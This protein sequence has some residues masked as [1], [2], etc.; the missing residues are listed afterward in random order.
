MEIKQ[1]PIGSLKPHPK[2]P[3]VHPDSAIEKLMRSI[4]EF[5]WTNPI[6]V[7]ED[8][9][10]M[11]GHARVKA[12]IKAGINE[13]PVIY[14]PLS[15]QKAEM[16][17]LTDNGVQDEAEWDMPVLAELLEQFKTSNLDATLTAFDVGEIDKIIN[18]L[19]PKQGLT[20]D[21]AIPEP[22]ESICKRGELWQL[23]NHRLLCGDATLSGDVERL[24]GSEKADMVFTDPPYSSGGYQEAGKS[25]GSIGSR[26]SKTIMMDNLSTRGYR[27]LIE[28]TL[29]I[30]TETRILFMFTDWRMWIESFDIA[31]RIGFRVRNML[32]WDKINFGMGSPFRSQHEL[33]LFGLKSSEDALSPANKGNVFNIKR[34]EHK[35]HFTMKPV[36][37]IT[38]VIGNV[39][40]NA[41]YDPFGGSGST[42]IAC[43]KLDRRCFMMEIDTSYTS[44]I[45]ERWTAYTG[46]DAVREDGRKWS[47]LK[48]EM[49]TASKNPIII[50]H[51]T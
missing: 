23:G 5:G 19:K 43:E 8:G 26:G 47:E 51:T 34:T 6:L 31:E 35:L 16:Y 40:S 41:I 15:G 11:A 32:V 27:K 45:I 2:N 3:R 12:A 38:E 4:S 36:E 33:I 18:D 9:Y 17:M 7:S 48:Q 22:T 37:L 39:E 10:I 46:K 1:V 28:D 30:H 42:L 50:N 24:M 25:G 20:D 13:V 29:N 21:D 49:M 14:L 44:V